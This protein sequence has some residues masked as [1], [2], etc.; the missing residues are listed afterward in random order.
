MAGRKR[1]DLKIIK[2]VPWSLLMEALDCAN[3]EWRQ[4]LDAVEMKVVEVPED[5]YVSDD[6][7]AIR[8]LSEEIEEGFRERYFPLPD[9]RTIREFE[10]MQAFA[11]GIEDARARDGLERVLQGRGA[12]RRFKDEIYRY[13]LDVKW[14]SCRERRFRQIAREWCEDHGFVFKDDVAEGVRYAA[15][16]VPKG[17]EQD[18][19]LPTGGLKRLVITGS[20]NAETGECLW[21]ETVTVTPMGIS[22]DYNPSADAGR[23]AGNWKYKAESEAF[24]AQF[25]KVGEVLAEIIGGEPADDRAYLPDVEISAAYADG[26]KYHGVFFS[27]DMDFQDLFV[28]IRRMI[29]PCEKMPEILTGLGD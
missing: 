14:H 10:M 19:T 20:R 17:R 22:C 11:A 13:G 12:F 24:A 4:Y 18:G 7:E 26:A 21:E 23:I 29:P 8:R 9:R 3:D 15:I 5:P 28:A 25:A 27:A 1:E 2:T 16:E 6:P